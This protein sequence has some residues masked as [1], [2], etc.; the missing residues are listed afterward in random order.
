MS[1]VSDQFL[2]GVNLRKEEDVIDHKSH[3]AVSFLFQPFPVSLLDSF[4]V[5]SSLS[6]SVSFSTLVSGI[7]WRVIFNTVF[8][9]T[10]GLAVSCVQGKRAAKPF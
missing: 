7:V 9:F 1:S 2:E 10:F 4:S 5:Y 6:F 3:G 8:S